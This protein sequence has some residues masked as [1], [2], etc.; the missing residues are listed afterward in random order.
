VLALAGCASAPQAAD[1]VVSVGM[2]RTE[3]R[4]YFGEP[5]RVE[6]NVAGGED[7]YYR[8]AAWETHPTGSTENREEFGEKTSYV[9]V[10]LGFSKH[11]QERP[12]HLSPEGYVTEPLPKGKLLKNDP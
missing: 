2:S 11:T 9:S 10:G 6:R 5:L 4:S 3:L 12:L 1:P 7:W 8:F